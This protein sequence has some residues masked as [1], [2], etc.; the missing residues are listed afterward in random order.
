MTFYSSSNNGL[1]L[2]IGNVTESVDFIA[3]TL[4]SGYVQLRYNLGSD[5]A[6]I[7]SNMTIALNQWQTVKASR[8]LKTGLISINGGA[9][10]SETS[11]GTSSQ[12]NVGGKGVYV[13]GVE[14]SSV[15]S[16]F[17]GTEMSFTGC[18]ESVKVM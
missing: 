18:I 9:G 14:E 10:S 2:Y 17:A 12:L 16:E 5:T 8:T 13:G 7:T 6:V 11:L 3:L 4:L 1:L 15:F